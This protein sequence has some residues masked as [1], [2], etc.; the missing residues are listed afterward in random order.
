[1][2]S[3]MALAGLAANTTFTASAV[4]VD[5]A[6]NTSSL[7]TTPFTTTVDKLAAITDTAVRSNVRAAVALA[8]TAESRFRA[9]KDLLVAAAETGWARLKATARHVLDEVATPNADISK[10]DVAA[11]VPMSLPGAI[12]MV[13]MGRTTVHL[14]EA[15]ATETATML[16]MEGDGDVATI[17]MSTAAGGT[18]YWR[19]TKSGAGPFTYAV[20]TSTDG[21]TFEAGGGIHSAGDTFVSVVGGFQASIIFNDPVVT[22]TPPAA[23]ASADPFVRSRFQ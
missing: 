12:T 13:R 15:E 21:T 20:E 19:V 16:L 11:L 17:E 3:V 22:I 14:S 18:L 2:R 4:V 7:L 5:A 1:M 10:A 23:T 6:G 9:A 8:G